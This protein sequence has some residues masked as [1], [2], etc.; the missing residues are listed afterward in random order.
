MTEFGQCCSL[1]LT[2]ALEKAPVADGA[3]HLGHGEG[4]SAQ[5]ALGRIDRPVQALG[6]IGGG[7]RHSEHELGPAAVERIDADD[8]DRPPTGLLVA[9]RGVQTGQPHFSLARPSAYSP[10]SLSS[11]SSSVTSHAATSA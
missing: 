7:Q 2:E 1:Y 5:A 11:P 9:D 6:A 4:A 3:G 8:H 10:G